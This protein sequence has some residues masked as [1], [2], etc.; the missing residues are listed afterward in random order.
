MSQTR[1]LLDYFM[2]PA[3]STDILVH[4]LEQIF[5]QTKPHTDLEDDTVLKRLLLSELEKV[6][7]NDDKIYFDTLIAIG[8]KSVELGFLTFDGEDNTP[9]DSKIFLSDENDSDKNDEGKADNNSISNL[10]IKGEHRHLYVLYILSDALKVA[11]EKFEDKHDKFQNIIACAINIMA[12]QF[13]KGFAISNFQIKD[14]VA[15]EKIGREW[16]NFDFKG[17]FD[18]RDEESLE[19]DLKVIERV[20]E[21]PEL[22]VV[23]L[24]FE[25]APQE[26]KDMREHLLKE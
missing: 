17:D 10:N 3:S 18:S 26:E 13:A 11:L 20:L 2:G 8:R 4:K 7:F 6:N 24:L 21:N 25:P 22:D 14:C 15:L 16:T 19:E 5:E 23:D 1:S 9:I 12:I